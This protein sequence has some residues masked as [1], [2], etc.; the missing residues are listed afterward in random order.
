[1]TRI[2]L[3]SGGYE[4]A[5]SMFRTS[6][7]FIAQSR[8]S[9]PDQLARMWY[10]QYNPASCSFVPLYVASESL[11]KAYTTGSL[12]KYDA[13]VAFWNFL[14]AGNYA[15]RFYRYAMVDVRAA[16][17]R[18]H[19]Q[20]VQ[21]TAAH[22]KTVLGLLASTTTQGTSAEVVQA[23]TEFTNAKSEFIQTEWRALLPHL[24]TKFHDG[25]IATGLDQPSIVMRKL[26][27][28]KWWLEATGY[29]LHK[30]NFGPGVILFEPTPATVVA[31]SSSALSYTATMVL[32][33]VCSSL[34]TVLGVMYV[35]HRQNKRHEYAPIPSANL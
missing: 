32:V 31:A 23:L 33:A 9:V 15:G 24:I 20:L 13:K 30:G 25:M 2:E 3:L 18:I 7:S 21:D 5:I 11:P 14:A 10:G 35:L 26:F 27:Y 16:I 1:M 28:P 12:F 34:V 29:F 22:E 4:R 17:A 6:Y 8:A 19:A